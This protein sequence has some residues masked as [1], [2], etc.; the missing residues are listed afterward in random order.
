MSTGG[1]CGRGI[2]ALFDGQA[3]AGQLLQDREAEGRVTAEEVLEGGAAEAQEITIRFGACAG[4]AY[5]RTKNSD[6]AEAFTRS[7]DIDFTAG[8]PDTNFAIQ[9]H[10]EAVSWFALLE[11]SGVRP[12][13]QVL[14]H[15]GQAEEILVVHSGEQVESFE[16]EE[17]FQEAQH[18]DLLPR[19]S[20]L[21]DR[22]AVLDGACAD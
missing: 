15:A 6:L 1:W 10:V 21:E 16:K 13:G 3:S 4:S 14:G 7:D 18:V 22:G 8:Q 2:T 12:H 20:V 11:Q 17:F 19:S 5:D 9:H